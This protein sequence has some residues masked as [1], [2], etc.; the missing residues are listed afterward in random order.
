MAVSLVKD[1]QD[2]ILINDAGVII[3]LAAEE[4]PL[5]GRATQGVTLM[6][7][8][9]GTVVDAAVVDRDDTDAAV[10]DRDEADA[11]VADRDEADAAVVDRDEAPEDTASPET[12][13]D[14]D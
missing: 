9:N 6:R 13:P 2:L 4:I 8:H 10:V 7:S 3:R 12:Q 1:E 11:A 14:T 5:Q